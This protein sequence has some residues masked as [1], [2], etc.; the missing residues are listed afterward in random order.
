M[1]PVPGVP[2]IGTTGLVER[3][4]M[5]GGAVVVA[6]G[7]NPIRRKLASRWNVVFGIV[8]APSAVLGIGVKIGPGSMILPSATINIDT[9]IGRHAILN[10]SCSVDH[11]CI[12]GDYAHVAP[13]C[14]LGGDVRVGEGTFL[15]IGVSVVPG[16]LIGR[17]AVIGAG[18]VVTKNIPDNCTAVGVPAKIIKNREDG[19]H[20]V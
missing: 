13:G 8:T 6:I 16:I 2:V 4:S 20:L 11:D 7:E 1:E 10:T 3:D 19:W 15:G 14:H 17:W 12:I 5:S 18:S 9:I